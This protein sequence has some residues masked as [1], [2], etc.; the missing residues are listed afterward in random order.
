[1]GTHLVEIGGSVAKKK[2]KKNSTL[3]LFISGRAEHNSQEG[4]EAMASETHWLFLFD[5]LQDL[6]PKL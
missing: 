6:S 1:M 2:K 4:E 3:T 5:E